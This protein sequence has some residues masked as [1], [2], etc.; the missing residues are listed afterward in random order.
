M[1]AESLRTFSAELH[2]RFAAASGDFNP[3]HMDAIAARRTAAGFPV[4]HGVHTLLWLLDWLATQEPAAPC[5]QTLKARFRK[6]VYVG[7]S[8][9]A[10]VQQRS[11]TALRARVLVGELEVL[12]LVLSG[13]APER[14]ASPL[15]VA[16][17]V[18]PVPARALDRAVADLPGSAGRLRFAAPRAAIGA[19]FPAATRWLGEPRV[20]ALAAA[21]ALVGMVIPGLHSIFGGLDLQRTDEADDG[22]LA[23]AVR[24]ADE[25]FGLVQMAI[26]G[27]GWRGA[28][29]A[30]CRP[31]PVTQAS[32]ERALHEVR[33][34]EFAPVTA[35]IVGGSRGIGEVTAKLL[36]AGGAHVCITY[37][38]GRADAEAVV[39]DIVRHGGSAE[40]LPYDVLQPPEIQ[41]QSLGRAITHLYYFPTPPIARRK[42]GLCDAQLLAE[43][44]AYYLTGFHDLVRVCQ[45][46]AQ[47]ELRVFYPSTVYV[48]SRPAEL[49][50]YAMIKAAGEVLCAD[51]ERFLRGVRIL[52]VR[53]PRMATDQTA[54]LVPSEAADPVAVMLPLLRHISN[55]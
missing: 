11:A 44:T 29:D 34:D 28:L 52:S 38:S 40:C 48:E 49:T 7:D 20:A 35:L 21:S 41:L 46:R 19:L 39:A 22:A 31:R 25:R 10:E 30:V 4:V 1:S 27:G 36:A 53:L 14:G 16:D 3:M 43:F 45:A 9:R 23:Y 33:R 50:E 54:S 13:V 18:A 12:S 8:V 15:A 55:A 26:E 42:S 32:M 17:A 51:L 2:G 37:R 5:P 47:A 6:M 24:G